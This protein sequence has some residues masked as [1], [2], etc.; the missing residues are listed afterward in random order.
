[1][2]AEPQEKLTANLKNLVPV[3]N[4]EDGHY[5]I[6]PAKTCSEQFVLSVT[7]ACANN[8]ALVGSIFFNEILIFSVN[9]HYLEFMCK[10]MCV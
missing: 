1:M 9:R 10:S 6:G 5:Q 3:L 4:E 2:S 8:L 7:I